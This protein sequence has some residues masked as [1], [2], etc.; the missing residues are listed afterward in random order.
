MYDPVRA[1]ESIAPPK[2]N[3]NSSMSA[4]GVMAVVMIVSGLRRMWRRD[5]PVSTEVS[6]MARVLIV[7]LLAER[8]WP[9]RRLSRG[10]RR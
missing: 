8:A 1:P 6:W 9:S 10:S 3:T 5:L 4:T 2:T 7:R